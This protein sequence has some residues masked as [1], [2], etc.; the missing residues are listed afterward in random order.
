MGAHIVTTKKSVDIILDD[1]C[2]AVR[3]FLNKAGRP[4]ESEELI[5]DIQEVIRRLEAQEP[6]KKPTQQKVAEA[7]GIEPRTLRA[8]LATCRIKWDEMLRLCGWQKRK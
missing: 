3:A 8:R 4:P 7:L 1:F 5:Q 2:E 6:G